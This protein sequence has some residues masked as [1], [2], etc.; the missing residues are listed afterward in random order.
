M[1]PIP[2]EDHVDLRPHADCDAWVFFTHRRDW[3]IP[4]AITGL[5]SINSPRVC[6][7]GD[8]HGAGSYEDLVALGIDACFYQHPPSYFYRFYPKEMQ[9]WWI[10]QGVDSRLY[11]SVKPWKDRISD[12]CLLTGALGGELYAFRNQASQLQGVTYVAPGGYSQHGYAAGQWD[13]DNYKSLLDSYQIHIASGGYSFCNKYL[14]S[15][16][17]GC[18]TIAHVGEDTNAEI[19]EAQSYYHWIPVSDSTGIAD[20]L[21]SCGPEQ[22]QA[23]A[24][25]GREFVLD[26]YTHRHCAQMLIERIESM[27]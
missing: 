12:T 1:V 3:G 2:G 21:M 9:Y 24:E 22:K 19:C 17:A 11:S 15:M 26:R 23:I 8:P 10:P 14:E 7:V 25:T 5:A 27:M 16:A 6:F 20:A 4:A 13:G 18:C